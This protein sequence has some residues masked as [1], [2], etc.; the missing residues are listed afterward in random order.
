MCYC[1]TN[2]ACAVQTILRTPNWR[3][4]F[5]LYHWLVIIYSEY[6]YIGLYI[7]IHIFTCVV[8]QIVSISSQTIF[9]LV[10]SFLF[11]LSSKV[12][13]FIL[14]RAHFNQGL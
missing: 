8:N 14:D 7:Y 12:D 4:R 13:S 11:T 2:L 5:R 6:I 1:F 10:L 3:P 9:A